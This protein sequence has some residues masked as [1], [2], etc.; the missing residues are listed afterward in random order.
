VMSAVSNDTATSSQ[1]HRSNKTQRRHRSK[2]I[3]AAIQHLQR[4][5]V[6]VCITFE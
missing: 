6:Q 5:N 2:Q 1:S 3:P 4:H